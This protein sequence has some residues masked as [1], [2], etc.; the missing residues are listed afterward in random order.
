[1]DPK[2]INSIV[3]RALCYYSRTL[4]MMPTEAVHHITEA[5]TTTCVS[6]RSL[7][8]YFAEVTNEQDI[9]PQK[10][11][12]VSRLNPELL[13]DI[14]SYLST[15]PNTSVRKMAQQFSHSPSTIHKYIQQSGFTYHQF[16]VVPYSLTPALKRIRV[17][18]AQVLASMLRVLR[19]V[20][21]L[22]VVT[23]DKH[24]LITPTNHMDATFQLQ[25]RQSH[26]HS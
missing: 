15:T 20:N 22:P 8:Q 19:K 23:T 4:N 24:G 6:P 14:K 17:N 1:M 5:F 2:L 7:Y 9:I 16:Q 18:H 3:M 21:Y 11:Q 12:S 25:H 13:E 26:N 10:Q